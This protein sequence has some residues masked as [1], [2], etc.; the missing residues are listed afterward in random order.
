M[1]TTHNQ[2]AE[3]RKVVLSTMWIFV[4][5]NMIYADILGMMKPGYLE[6][7]DLLSKSLSGEMVLGFSVLMEIPILMVLL[8]RYLDRKWNRIVNIIGAAISI[9]WVIVPSFVSSLGTTPLSYVFF[10]MVETAAMLFII[11]YAYQW[12]DVNKV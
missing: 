3:K 8:S 4:L 6:N 11:R 9:L 7:L 10:A 5:I 12:P 2:I 1:E